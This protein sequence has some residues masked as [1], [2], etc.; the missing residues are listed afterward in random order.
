MTGTNVK[1]VRL[2]NLAIL[3]IAKAWPLRRPVSRTREVVIAVHDLGEPFLRRVQ[4]LVRSLSIPVT[5]AAQSTAGG[6]DDR[7]ACGV[8]AAVTPTKTGS[9]APRMVGAVPGAAVAVSSRLHGALQSILSGVPAVHLAYERKGYGAYADLG[10]HEFVHPAASFD[11]ALV[12]HQV[13]RLAKDPSPHWS[14]VE[15]RIDAL[16]A[17]RQRVVEE[18]AVTPSGRPYTDAGVR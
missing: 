10:L 4:A 13:L 8:V 12:R 14:R 6:N 11:P 15:E 9:D 17:A 5:V 1:V 7:R 2:P 16:N 3:A 18:L